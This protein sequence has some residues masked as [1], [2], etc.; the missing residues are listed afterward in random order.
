MTAHCSATRTQVLRLP[1]Q[2]TD[3]LGPLPAAWHTVVA[4]TPKLAWLPSMHSSPGSST[5]AADGQQQQLQRPG[6]AGLVPATDGAQWQLRTRPE[7]GSPEKL[8]LRP[9]QVPGPV[10][11]AAVAHPPQQLLLQA[12]SGA[13]HAPHAHAFVS[14][15]CVRQALPEL[16]HQRQT[17][18]CLALSRVDRDLA[19]LVCDMLAYD[20]AQRLSAAAALR[21]PLFTGMLPYEASSTHQ[22]VLAGGGGQQ[23]PP[24]PA[25]EAQPN[26]G[27]QLSTARAQRQ[28][29]GSL[30]A[31]RWPVSAK[32][33]PGAR[34]RGLP[35]APAGGNRAGQQ[36]RAADVPGG[37]DEPATG[38][39]ALSPK[40]AGA[41]AG[42]AQVVAAGLPSSQ[43]V[44]ETP[45]SASRRR[46][47]ASETAVH[48]DLAETEARP[49]CREQQQQQQT[50]A[51]V[52]IG[53]P[54]SSAAALV[55]TETPEVPSPLLGSAAWRSTGQRRSADGNTARRQVWA[56][57]GAL[58]R[59]ID[60][61]LGPVSQKISCRLQDTLLGW[62]SITCM[63]IA[64]PACDLVPHAP[65]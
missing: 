50:D 38:G 27:G 39:L 37:G 12:G 29:V 7:K 5:P 65:A 30:E 19:A 47:A 31:E 64:C 16:W 46:Q 21:S 54:G 23:K 56:N 13:G 14:S 9:E 59:Q 51:H 33:L 53:V 43:T 40:L 28:A 44:P 20:P 63:M 57:V 52:A 4:G 49:T 36:G 22:E 8:G 24:G 1:V 15:L 17:S 2:M 3:T 55:N 32:G 62:V 42:G 25:K 45:Q 18:L 60:S 48:D 58:V 61:E 41:G 35:T 6:L 10:A 26:T 34:L 11:P